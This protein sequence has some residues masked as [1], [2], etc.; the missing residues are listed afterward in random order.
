MLKFQLLALLVLS[1][2]GIDQSKNLESPLLIKPYLISLIV[3]N[4][5]VSID[6]YMQIL[7]FEED[8]T[9]H[10]LDS[11]NLTIDFLKLGNFRLEIISNALATQVDRSKLP[12]EYANVHGLIKIG[13][14]TADLEKIKTQ[15]LEKKAEVIVGPADLPALK[16]GQSWPN[17]FFLLK[18]PDGNYVQFFKGNEEFNKKYELK[19][20]FKLAPFLAMYSVKNFDQSLKWFQEQVG[21]EFVEGVGEP[22]NQRGI[23]FLDNF[24]VEI[25]SFTDDRSLDELGMY[26]ES[27]DIVR[28]NKL[29]FKTNRIDEKYKSAK[30]NNL[31]IPFE[32]M[33]PG[34]TDPYFIIKDPEGNCIQ[35][36]K[37]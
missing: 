9:V 34:S 16:S 24:V 21:F 28:L 22:G 8:T 2:C 26:E 18:D 30:A 12:N 29:G 6:W 13:F 25:G 37:Q 11:G 1:S 35:F 17:Q 15:A 3:E 10:F 31:T 19:G 7:D 33:N 27:N 14:V 36:F 32:E 20:E 4:R 5:E 23:L